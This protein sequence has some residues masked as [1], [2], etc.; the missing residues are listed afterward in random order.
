[1]VE[2]F[3]LCWFIQAQGDDIAYPFIEQAVSH[4]LA[5]IG[6][7]PAGLAWPSAQEFIAP[8]TP[9]MSGEYMADV[10]RLREALLAVGLDTRPRAEAAV[11]RG[12][13][14]DIAGI[15]GLHVR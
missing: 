12:E 14:A 2:F 13:H 5:R 11:T 9:V 7:P 6:P 15:I 10:G 3:S 1:W 4:H 8:T